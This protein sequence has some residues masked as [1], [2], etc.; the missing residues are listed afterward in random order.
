MI[1]ADGTGMAEPVVSGAA[2]EKAR[3]LVG[4]DATRPSTK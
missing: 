1:A 4:G 3:G 2:I